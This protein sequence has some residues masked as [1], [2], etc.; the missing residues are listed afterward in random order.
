MTV[1]SIPPVGLDST[2]G[3]F[4]IYDS[5]RPR[6]LFSPAYCGAC[7]LTTSVGTVL[8]AICPS[9]YIGD[10]SRFS[11]CDSR[12]LSLYHWGKPLATDR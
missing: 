10:L 5:S 6:K 3:P 8:G 4:T 1:Y 11:N 7:H 12:S 9:H 2:K